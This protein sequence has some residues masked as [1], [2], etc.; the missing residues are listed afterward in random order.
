MSLR[1]LHLTAIIS[2]NQT[3]AFKGLTLMFERTVAFPLTNYIPPYHFP[4]IPMD[5]GIVRI[6]DS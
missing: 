1:P 6:S 2:I 3:F 5:A 4:S